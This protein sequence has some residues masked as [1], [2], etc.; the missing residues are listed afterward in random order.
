VGGQ[1]IAA[2]ALVDTGASFAILLG[3][4][5]LPKQCL[6]KCARPVQLTNASG[7]AME[8]GT[9]GASVQIA[10]PVV[11]DRQEAG[12]VVEALC[13]ALWAVEMDM[14]G[15]EVILGYPFLSLF[16]LLVD[17]VAHCLRFGTHRVEG[18]AIGPVAQPKVNIGTVTSRK[19]L[20]RTARSACQETPEEPTVTV[21]ER[22]ENRVCV[23]SLAKADAS[24]QTDEVEYPD[25]ELWKS[26]VWKI[27]SRRSS[28]VS[29]RVTP[30]REECGRNTVSRLG[31][32][33][34]TVE[35]HASNSQEVV[36]TSTDFGTIPEWQ[37]QFC[38]RDMDSPAQD[39]LRKDMQTVGPCSLDSTLQATPHRAVPEAVAPSEMEPE[40]E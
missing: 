23:S 13:S 12:N 1:T 29:G 27:F 18:A 14:P 38:P 17:P 6:S 36:R 26:G 21:R 16:R 7:V 8:G 3:R 10:L 24:L 20:L 34:S 15:S 35:S 25:R 11:D 33:T 28:P 40:D 37:L 5:L 19:C 22:H 31:S 4:G 9:H 2:R 32:Y 39:V 30:A